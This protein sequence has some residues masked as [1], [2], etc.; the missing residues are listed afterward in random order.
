MTAD[1]YFEDTRIPA[2]VVEERA[3]RLAGGLARLGVEDGD[4][5]AV[6]LRNSPAFIDAIMACQTAGC[7]YCPINW[8]FTAAEAGYLLADSGA[9][10]VLIHA[11]LHAAIAPVIP[12]GVTVLVVANGAAPAEP[13]PAAALDY[14]GWLADQSPY[15]GPAR[16]PRGHMAYTSGTTGRPKGVRRLAPAPEQADAQR[17]QMIAMVETAWGVRPG[18]RVL[19]SA[20]LY[21]SAPSSVTQ[22]GMLQG[23]AFVLAPRFD[24]EQTLALIQHYRID[25]AFLVPIMF[26]RLLRLPLSVRERYDLSSLRFVASTGAPCPPQVKREMLDWW[27]DVIYETYASSETGMITIQSPEHARRKPA[28]VGPPLGDAV[29]RIL[30]DNGRECA[31]GE[32]G[33]IYCHQPAITDFTYQ[34]RDADR[35]AA[36]RDGLVT[37]GDIGYLDADGDLFV[38][39]R[40]SDLVISGGVNIYPAEIENTLMSL[41][42]IA[43]CAVFGVADAEYGQSLVAMVCADSSADWSET[44]LRARLRE[45]IAAYKVPRAIECVEALARDDNGKIAKHRLKQQ[46]EA[47]RS[48]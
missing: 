40:Y 29:I 25:T 48:G 1:L 34:N 13:L 3:L 44:T 38:C 16:T 46:W 20:P 23:E 42:G 26:V 21:H 4:V 8:H 5:I 36:G 32:A 10:V 28:S 35:A 6:M 31:T 17:Q 27:G 2:D 14:E 24:A 22:Q 39:D 37:V 33:L 11:D 19:V 7:F 43:D 18:V 41:P 9:K 45:M 47:R 12:D 15:D 30:D